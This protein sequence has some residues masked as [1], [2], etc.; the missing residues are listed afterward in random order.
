MKE[1]GIEVNDAEDLSAKEKHIEVTVAELKKKHGIKEVFV[2]ECDGLIAYV[3]RPS[4]AQLAYAMTMA[5]S[6]P[7]GMA[8]E[9][10][11]SGWLAGDE[12]LQT[13]DKYFLSISSQ[14]DELNETTH[15]Q[16]KKY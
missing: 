1:K 2:F 5:Q 7:L 13:E 3:K 9:L 16:V 11:K 15:V 6:N 10:L 14:I 12:E 8:E 4:R